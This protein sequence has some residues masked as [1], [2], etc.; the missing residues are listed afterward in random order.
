MPHIHLLLGV[1]ISNI[2]QVNSNLDLLFLLGCILPDADI[3]PGF[4]Q[5]KN[6]R[7]YFSHYPIIWL[8]FTVLALVLRS[9]IY[10]FFLGGF[11]H[12][13]SDILDWKVY[14]FAPFSNYSMSIFNFNPEE[15]LKE[16]SPKT[17]IKNYYQKPQVLII[18]LFIFLLG[19]V[20]I[21]SN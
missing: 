11:I 15:I 3:I 7:T 16:S 20:S 1:I 14:I 9:D 4:L 8:F 12:V 6:H 10:W 5:K 2:L 19:L 21:I 17:S 18:E 13:I